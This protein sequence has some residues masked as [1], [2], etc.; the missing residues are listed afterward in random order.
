MSKQAN[1]P[2]PLPE[3]FPFQI[4]CLLTDVDDT[5]TWQ[6]RLPTK[7]FVAMEKLL[8]KGIAVVPVT[9]ACG[10][11]CDCIIRT[12]PVSAVISENGAFWLYRD[13]DGRI[14]E[15]H[16]TEEAIRRARKREL[17]RLADSLYENFPEARL[18]R[19][20]AYRR[21]DI[22]FD[23]GQDH[24]VE[25]ERVAEMV[26][27]CKTHGAKALASSIHIN[28]WMGSYGKDSTTLSWLEEQMIDPDHTIFVGDSPMTRPCSLS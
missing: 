17:E 27:F 6:G 15:H 14:R 23:I 11:W 4:K 3:H 21:C 26:R 16:V 28:V 24:F 8:E 19:D 25:A 12:W 5:L 18:T 1:M 10:G 9:G 13:S 2:K 7:A 22:A 20:S